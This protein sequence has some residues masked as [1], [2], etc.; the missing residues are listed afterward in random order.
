MLM[1]GRL[2]NCMTFLNANDISN[3]VRHDAIY[4]V[5]RYLYWPANVS[6]KPVSKVLST[7][8]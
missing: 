1:L 6:L 7:R 3:R 4:F 5:A 2:T 8:L